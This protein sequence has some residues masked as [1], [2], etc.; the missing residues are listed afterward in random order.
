[1]MYGYF[2]YSIQQDAK[3]QEVCSLSFGNR[4]FFPH[5]YIALA[6]MNALHVTLL[7]AAYQY[8][9]RNNK[10]CYSCK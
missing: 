8:S 3:S 6:E 10:H 7:L 5:D 4:H 2:T 9:S 1:M